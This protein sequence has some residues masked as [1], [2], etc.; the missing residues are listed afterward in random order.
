MLWVNG[1]GLLEEATQ[2]KVPIKIGIEDTYL[3]YPVSAVKPSYTKQIAALR[4]TLTT[5]DQL[6]TLSSCY[7]AQGEGASAMPATTQDLRRMSNARIV[8]AHY[9]YASTLGHDQSLTQVYVIPVKLSEVRPKD[10]PSMAQGTQ[11]SCADAAYLGAQEQKDALL[12]AVA[13]RTQADLQQ[14]QQALALI[15]QCHGGMQ[16]QSGE[17]FYLHPIAVAQLVLDYNQEEAT[18]LGALLHDTLEDTWLSASQLGTL[19]NEEVQEIVVRLTHLKLPQDNLY[20]VKL[21]RHENI[22]MLLGVKDHRVLY[23]KIAE[24]LHTMR[25]IQ[26]KSYASQQRTAEETWLFFVPLA[27]KLGLHQAAA[28]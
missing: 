23:I 17:P 9:G 3:G 27:E 8:Q 6:P 12:S 4:F 15:K 28:A 18:V 24:R 20:K 16:R 25:T 5:E 13:K 11:V 10:L 21:S 22:P 2:A 26:Y 14:V 7:L 19:F 1:I